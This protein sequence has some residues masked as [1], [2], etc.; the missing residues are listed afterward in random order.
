LTEDA[1]VFA[2]T[3]VR[4]MMERK[5]VSVTIRRVMVVAMFFMRTP[6]KHELFIE[7]LLLIRSIEKKRRYVII[8]MD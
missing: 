2:S 1:G 3:N 4:C 8:P 6:C 5:S 7:F